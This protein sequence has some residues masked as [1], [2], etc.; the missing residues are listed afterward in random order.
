MTV[1]EELCVSSLFSNLALIAEFV[2]DRASR[3]GLSEDGV[4]AVQMAVDEACSNS[5]EHA[6]EGS[7]DGEVRV[8]CYVQDDD[9]VVRIIDHGRPFDPDSVPEPDVTGPIES[10][11]IGGLGLFF[12]NKLMDS[13]RHERRPEGG[14][15]VEMRKRL[16]AGARGEGPLRLS[17]RYDASNTRD[18]EAR[19]EAAEGSEDARLRVDMTNVTYISSSALRALLIAHRRQAAAGGQLEL[20]NVPERVLRVLRMAGFDRV[21][22]IAGVDASPGEVGSPSRG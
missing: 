8:C 16:P 22:S 4:F 1:Q 15:L 11:N 7:A 20:Q 14:N 21:F 3:L 9:L 19:L 2:A 17:G 13:V 12:M 6:Y 18:L 5:I 10:R